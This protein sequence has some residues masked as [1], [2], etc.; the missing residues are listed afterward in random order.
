MTALNVVVTKTGK[1]RAVCE[2][3]GRLSAPKPMRNDR[4][5]VG[6]F[7][8]TPGWSVAP[9]PDDYTHAFDGSKG[10]LYTCP[11]CAKSL[12]GRQPLVPRGVGGTSG[13]SAR[14]GL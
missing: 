3:C 5:D 2:F 9:F 13:P 8:L 11:T 7:D 6:I 12:V 14:S 10:S 4:I 1:V